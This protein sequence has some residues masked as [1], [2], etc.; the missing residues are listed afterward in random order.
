MMINAKELDRKSGN[1]TLAIVT[2]AVTIV[3]N[4]MVDYQRFARSISKIAA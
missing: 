2:S 1:S 3:L 4:Q